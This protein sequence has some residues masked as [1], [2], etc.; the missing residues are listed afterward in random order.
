M[1]LMLRR[2]I[3]ESVD[4]SLDLAAAGGLVLIDPTQL[5]P[6]LVNLVINAADAMPR[7]GR[8]SIETRNVTLDEHYRERHLPG[9]PRQYVKTGVSDTGRGVRQGGWPR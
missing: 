4:I 1:Q 2:L 8:L 5:E 9:T 3:V 7:G 6:I